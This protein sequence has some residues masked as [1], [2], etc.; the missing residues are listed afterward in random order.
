MSMDAVATSISVVV[1]VARDAPSL[2]IVAVL[3]S[4][5]SSDVLSGAGKTN[6]D[7]NVDVRSE[8]KDR[9][10]TGDRKDVARDNAQN[11]DDDDDDDDT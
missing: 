4:L 11:R 10:R 7:L 6:F 8:R 1:A 2:L 5:V 9:T 3:V